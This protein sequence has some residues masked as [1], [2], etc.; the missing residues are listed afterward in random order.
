MYLNEEATVKYQGQ[1][2]CYVCGEKKT[3]YASL[4][5]IA[6]FLSMNFAFWTSQW[7]VV[8]VFWSLWDCPRIWIIE[9]LLVWR[10]YFWHQN[11]PFYLVN[12]KEIFRESKKIFSKIHQHLDREYS[13]DILKTR[14]ITSK[15]KFFYEF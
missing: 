13:K 10:L 1:L 2:V 15:F 5:D 6:C 3:R 7:F 11:W 4:M 12:R 8:W 9:M 14:V